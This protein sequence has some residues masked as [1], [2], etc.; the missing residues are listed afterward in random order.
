MEED[1]PK[2]RGLRKTSNQRN[3][4]SLKVVLIHS[5]FVIMGN[6]RPTV[7]PSSMWLGSYYFKEAEGK[8]RENPPKPHHRG[9]PK[10][11]SL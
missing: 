2:E 11:K 7:R 4:S 10:N 9:I 3:V 5:V 1:M 6:T 8:K